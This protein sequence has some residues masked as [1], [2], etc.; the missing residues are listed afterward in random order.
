MQH[1]LLLFELPEAKQNRVANRNVNCKED[2]SDSQTSG[3]DVVAKN[4]HKF[5]KNL[6]EQKEI[7]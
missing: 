3:N 1:L 6:N 4:F 2:P 7:K 5:Y